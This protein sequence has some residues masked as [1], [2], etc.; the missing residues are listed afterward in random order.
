LPRSPRSIAVTSG[1]PRRGCVCGRD[2]IAGD[3][4]GG[5]GRR[6]ALPERRWA[7][8]GTRAKRRVEAPDAGEAG[9][10]RDRG[11]RHRG[12]VDQRLR[13]LHPPGHRHGRRRGARVLAEEPSQVARASC[14]SVSARPATLWPSSRNPRSMSRTG[15]GDARRRP[16][17]PASRVAASVRQ[18][19]QAGTPPARRRRGG[20]EDDVARLRRLHRTGMG[21]NRSASSAHR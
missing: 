20:K 21:G 7:A 13:P 1:P 18:R 11:H 16:A 14:P 8:A 17:T 12:S 3:D 10:E 5:V 19:R 4:R 9:G 15:T 2:S 6:R